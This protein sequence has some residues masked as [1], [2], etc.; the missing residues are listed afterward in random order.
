MSKLQKVLIIIGTILVCI[1]LS[2]VIKPYSQFSNYKN[3]DVINFVDKNFVSSDLTYLLTFL[4]V[5]SFKFTTRTINDNEVIS[6]TS[7]IDS[8]SN[9][10]GCIKSVDKGLTFAIYSSDSLFSIDYRKLLY[11]VNDYE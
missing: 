9:N 8:F 5:D 1:V 11:E 6:K 10:D 4:S 7:F 3:Y 2:Y